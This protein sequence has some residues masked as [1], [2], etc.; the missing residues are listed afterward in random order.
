MNTIK[1][2]VIKI[3]NG[4]IITYHTTSDEYNMPYVEGMKKENTYFSTDPT[5]LYL[6]LMK[7]IEK[8]TGQRVRSAC[9]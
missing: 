1:W 6:W 2:R 5:V 3:S 7:Q 4:Y 9:K 8:E